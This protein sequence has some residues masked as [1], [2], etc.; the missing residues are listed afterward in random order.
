M[1]CH[2]HRGELE[3]RDLSCGV[4]RRESCGQPRSCSV[5]ATHQSIVRP[6]LQLSGQSGFLPDNHETVTGP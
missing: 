1:L 5:C 4:G 3:Q 6:G 2:L